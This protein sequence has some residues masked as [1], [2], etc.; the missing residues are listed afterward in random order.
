MG[1][2]DLEY[3]RKRALRAEMLMKDVLRAESEDTWHDGGQVRSA[4]DN[5]ALYLEKLDHE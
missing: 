5:I 2:Q 1:E 3:W 4:I